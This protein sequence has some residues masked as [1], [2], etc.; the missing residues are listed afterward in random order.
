MGGVERISRRFVHKSPVLDYSDTF[1]VKKKLR[2]S[3]P[4]SQV[5]V[6]RPTSILRPRKSLLILL[7]CRKLKFVSCTVNLSEQI[8]PRQTDPIVSRASNPSNLNPAS[9]EMVSDSVNC[10]RLKF[11]CYTHLIGA[12]VWIPTMQVFYLM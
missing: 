12:N 6:F 9:K 2:R 3:D 1:S 7:N 5:R 11:V 10:A 8:E 4:T